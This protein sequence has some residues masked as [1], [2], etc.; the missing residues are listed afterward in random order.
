MGLS[1]S[2][3]ATEEDYKKAKKAA[4]L[5]KKEKENGV[6]SSG[7]KSKK[8][9]ASEAIDVAAGKIQEVKKVKTS[10]ADAD[11]HTKCEPTVIKVDTEKQDDSELDVTK[12]N[13]SAGTR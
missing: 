10:V 11:K 5:L 1:R 2:D 3:F 4:K 12:F 8:R 7:E 6:E 13:I 9:S